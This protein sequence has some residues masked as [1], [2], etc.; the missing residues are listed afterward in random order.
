MRDPRFLIV[1]GLWFLASCAEPNDPE[2]LTP[3]TGGYAIVSKFVTPGYAQDVVVVDTLAYVAQGEGGLA[4]VNIAD[5]LTPRLVSVCQEGVRGYS[6]KV[7]IKDSA[8]FVASGSFGVNVVDVI[9]PL[10]P[11]ATA[12]NLAMKPA[13]SMHVYGNYLFTAVSEQGIKIAEISYPVQPDIRGGVVTP[14]YAQG[15]STTADSAYLLVACGEMGF[16]MYDIRDIRAGFGDYR[17]VGWTDTPGYAEDV[18]QL[19]TLRY[20]LVACG[21]AGLQVVDFTDTTL[22][23]VSGSFATGGYAKEVAFKNGRAYVTT[24]MRGLQVLSVANPRSPQLLGVVE[25][26]F[27]L[28]VDVHDRVA[29]LADEKEGLII[30]SIPIY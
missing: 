19:D 26:E 13:R 5:P 10:V 15:I 23:Q 29:Y 25:T 7:A 17:L 30:I 11:V 22:V 14:G 2:S 28:G 18:V 9:N 21:T 24:E 6:H 3:D 8:V 20:A 12:S 1:C 27:A 16:A 4:V